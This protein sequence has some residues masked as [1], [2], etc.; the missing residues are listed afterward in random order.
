MAT[1]K[2]NGQDEAQLIQSHLNPEDHAETGS[3]FGG[4]P[5]EDQLTTS[6]LSQQLLGAA[7]SEREKSGTDRE[8]S[9]VSTMASDE[10]TMTEVSTGDIQE[11]EDTYWTIRAMMNYFYE[12]I[13]VI[14]ERRDKWDNNEE[15]SCLIGK[16]PVFELR[17]RLIEEYSKRYFKTIKDIRDFSTS[18]KNV[19]HM[20]ELEYTEEHILRLG[21]VWI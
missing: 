3:V 10:R 11:L 13:A 14:G 12:M 6:T 7:P 2:H 8:E 16:L 5:A 20:P 17:H 9:L 21:S 15:I 1:Q 18:L 19:V 4:G